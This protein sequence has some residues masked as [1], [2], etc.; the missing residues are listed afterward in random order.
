M[1]SA[2]FAKDL[3]EAAEIADRKYD[4]SAFRIF[5]SGGAPI[6]PKLIPRTQRLLGARML[7]CWGMTEVGIATIGRLTDSDEKLSSSDGAPVNGVKLRIVDD[8]G[9]LL[10]ANTPGH[11]EIRAN[12]QHVGFFMNDTLYAQSFR[13]GWYK[14]GDLGLLDDDGYIRIVGRSKDLVIRGGENIPIIEVENVLLEHPEIADICIV[15]VPDG[16]LG[17]RCHAVVVPRVPGHVLELT[18]LAD[19]LRRNEVTKQYW[20]EYMSLAESLP[21]TASG[22]IQRF[23]VRDQ[24]ATLNA[25]A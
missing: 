10:P 9:G 19:H 11:I 21:K 8:E 25:R 1:G 7:P 22:K 2:A 17:E 24:V 14:T 18:D 13:D 20:P 16:R 4:T 23:V 12:G 3:C 5:V 6:P 15:G